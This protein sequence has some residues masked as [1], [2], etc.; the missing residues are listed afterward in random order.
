MV[1]DLDTARHA[2]RDGRGAGV[3]IAVIDSGIEVDHPEL[4]GITLRDD[5]QVADTGVMLEVQPGGGVD[6]YGH[7][8]AVAGVIRRIAPEAE[9]GSIRVLGK[10]LGSRTIII[11]EGVR[12]AIDR[13]Y[14]ILNCSFGCG[15]SEHIFQ[16]KEWIDE[17][18][19]KGIHVVSACNNYDFSKPEWPGYF[20][21][22]VTINMAR[23]DDDTTFFRKP[24]H[25]VEFAARGV[26]VTLPWNNRTTK[27]VTG[28]SFA[29]PVV[30]ALLARLLSVIPELTP[31]E[32]KAL[33]H[34]LAAPWQEE[35]AAPNVVT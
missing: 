11:R 12:Q 19:L 32:A 30:S 21:S 5:I 16:Y 22:V 28:S 26:N 25:L 18:Y 27:E 3:S 31:L 7:G 1:V 34:R 33:L 35:H 15:L 14:K 13:G 8:T 20:P 9:I 23:H 17:A 2:I 10:N 4:P 6:V 29:A 24:G